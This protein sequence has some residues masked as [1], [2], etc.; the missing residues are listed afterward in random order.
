MKN[1]KLKFLFKVATSCTLIALILIYVDLSKTLHTLAEIKISYLII[2][3][4][5]SFL[6][7][8][9]STYKWKIILSIDGFAV[10]FTYLFKSYLIGHFVSLF[11]PTSI[12]GDIYRIAAVKNEV[13]DFSTGASSVIFDRVSGLYA[14]LVLASTGSFAFLH[15]GITI[16]LILLVLSAPIFAYFFTKTKAIAKFRDGKFQALEDLGKIIESQKSYISS[17]KLITVLII[18]IVFQSTAIIINYVYCQALSIQIPFTHL[19]AIV[20]LVY[21]TDVIP[22]SINGIGVRDSAFVFFFT[23]MGYAAESAL[24]LSITLISMRYLI[25]MTGGVLLLRD[26]LLGRKIL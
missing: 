1:T 23:L 14:L 17:K 10:R 7:T 19:W 11:L 13:G 4:V 20:P 3:I 9:I 22:L 24:A 15:S 8:A 26:F 21:L 2:P 18:S 6:Q 12:G 25:G 16:W 5:I